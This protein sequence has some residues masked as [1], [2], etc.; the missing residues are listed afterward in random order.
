M[1]N[2]ADCLRWI[3]S[4]KNDNSKLELEEYSII[5]FSYQVFKKCS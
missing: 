5:D 4:R 2:L 3:L 1:H